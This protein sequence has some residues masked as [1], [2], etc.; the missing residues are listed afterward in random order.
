MGRCITGI[1]ELNDRWSDRVEPHVKL[2]GLAA[3]ASRIGEQSGTEG[4]K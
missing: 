3:N 1:D 2:I 4:C